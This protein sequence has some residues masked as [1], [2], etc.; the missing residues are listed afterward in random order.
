[1]SKNKFNCNNCLKAYSSKQRLNCHVCINDIDTF[2]KNISSKEQVLY[3]FNE[4]KKLGI[5]FDINELKSLNNSKNEDNNTITKMSQNDNN[6]IIN[7]TFINIQI[8]YNLGDKIDLKALTNRTLYSEYYE[9]THKHFESIQDCLNTK[10][11]IIKNNTG[12]KS[13]KEEIKKMENIIRINSETIIFHLTNKLL[14]LYERLFFSEKNPEYHMIYIPTKNSNFYIHINNQWRNIGNLDFLKNF[15]HKMF[16]YFTIGCDKYNFG[17]LGNI[18][19]YIYQQNMDKIIIIMAE[20]F[21][22]TAYENKDI[23][24]NTFEMTKNIKYQPINNNVSDEIIDRLE[25][26]SDTSLKH[27]LKEEIKMNQNKNDKNDKN[28]NSWKPSNNVNTSK[29]YK[30]YNKKKEELENA[31]KFEELEKLN[32]MSPWDYYDQ[33]PSSEIELLDAETKIETISEE[34][35]ESNP[36]NDSYFGFEETEKISDQDEKDNYYND[37]NNDEDEDENN[38]D[39]YEIQMIDG[40]K[41]IIKMS[42]SKIYKYKNP[43]CEEELEQIGI[44]LPNNSCNFFDNRY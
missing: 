41:Y 34:I 22:V 3:L 12:T 18:T 39:G 19:R 37:E 40:K 28:N 25:S 33:I 21:F 2:V 26:F 29:I 9:N 1:M 6:T 42:E 13:D 30:I 35:L 27:E 23:V 44:I 15:T 31:D 11:A 8:V 32:K 5:K 20:R 43:I 4:V 7:N 24:S 36:V 17:T 38:D 16:E 14:E 10:N